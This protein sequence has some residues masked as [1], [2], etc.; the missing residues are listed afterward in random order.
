MRAFKF[1]NDKE[2]DLL[3]LLGLIVGFVLEAVLWGLGISLRHT[4]AGSHI[5][6]WALIV[7]LV[8]FAVNF[9]QMMSLPPKPANAVQEKGGFFGGFTIGAIVSFLTGAIIWFFLNHDHVHFP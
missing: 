4:S 1:P 2:P 3:F 6:V 8:V 5:R 7:C 9:I